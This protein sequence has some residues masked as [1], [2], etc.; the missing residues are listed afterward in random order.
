MFRKTMTAALIGSLFAVGAAQAATEIDGTNI[1]NSVTHSTQEA[2]D[3]YV[4]NAISI[5]NASD[6]DNG[7]T[8][9]VTNGATVVIGGEGTSTIRLEQKRTSSGYAALFATKDNT[10]GH[11]GNVSMEA[12]DRIDILSESSGIW[13]QN[14]TQSSPRPE[15][16]TTVNLKARDINIQARDMAV[17]AFSNSEIN[18]NSTGGTI[19]IESRKSNAIDARGNSLVNINTDKA[20]ERVVIIGDIAFE[21]P[22]PTENSGTIINADLNIVLSGAESSWTGGI[23]FSYPDNLAEDV[24]TVTDMRLTLENGAQWNATQVAG[25]LPAASGQVEQNGTINSLTLNGGVINVQDVG[26]E[27]LIGKLSGTGGEINL[28]ATAKDGDLTGVAKLSI[29]GVSG[30]TGAPAP[31][32][33]V[34]LSGVTADDI[35]DPEKAFK[36]LSGAFSAEGSELTEVIEEGDIKGQITR[37]VDAEGNVEEVHQESNSKLSTLSSVTALSTIQWRAEMN[38]LTKRM[39]ELRDS[40]DGIGTWVRLYGSEQEYG[41]QSVTQK[42]ATVQVGADYAVGDWVVGGAFSYT[43]GTTD[44]DGGSGD[45][46]AYG[47]AV[48]GTWMAENGMFVDLIGKYSRL[49]SDFDIRNM[50]GEA[51]NNAFSM[52]A[53]F[54]WRFDLTNLVYVEPQA[55]LTYGRIM[56]DDFR[57]SNDVKVAQDDY[58]SL[59][60][61][62]GLRAGLKFP[63][64]K[65]SIYARLSGVYDFQGE[66]EASYSK[67]GLTETYRNDL[68]GGWMEY[69]VGANFN[70]TDR[71]YTYV[72]LEK[73]TG[74]EVTEKWRWNVGVRHVF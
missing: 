58:D 22:G 69:A 67:D 33:T 68:G 49:E 11:M 5:S 51:K 52:S 23:L 38:D 45:T 66:S 64:K 30:E 63:E 8:M 32:L 42:S 14:N 6:A 12:T 9:T 44:Y 36:V 60:G 41:E 34:A 19:W 53:E 4:G 15:S 55:E 48:Y 37:F 59:I 73:T 35:N 3:H 25:T 21:T 27:I 62:V 40:P 46:Q 20:A 10:T 72:D 74:G 61:R 16:H 17:V 13:A 39:G 1:T 29:E 57:T 31:A 18:I 56:G 2:V 43:D 26:D 65:G 24:R 71:T 54:G 70:L 7:D 47:F 28:A 50:S